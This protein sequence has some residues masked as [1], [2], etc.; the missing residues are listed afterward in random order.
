[1]LS[2]VLNAI[3]RS[4]HTFAFSGQPRGA[5]FQR[6]FT[7]LPHIYLF[8]LAHGRAFRSLSHALAAHSPFQLSLGTCT[9]IA[10]SRSRCI[11]AFSGSHVDVRFARYFTRLLHNHIFQL[12]LG[13]HIFIAISRSCCLFV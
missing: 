7:Q 2:N 1:M 5:H 10:I 11:F 9:F 6:Y 12:N 8:G 4:C 3:S 13:A